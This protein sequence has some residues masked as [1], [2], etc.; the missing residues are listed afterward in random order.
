MRARS[1]SKIAIV[2]ALAIVLGLV[3]SGRAG[4]PETKA[5]LKKV[6]ILC[7]G[8]NNASTIDDVVSIDVIDWK[9]M[10]LVSIGTAKGKQ[11]YFASDKVV[12]FTTEPMPEKAPDK[13]PIAPK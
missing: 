7:V 5:P 12:L 2:G 3:A 11:C 8:W 10:K 6:E 4:D 9:G 13:D 1:I